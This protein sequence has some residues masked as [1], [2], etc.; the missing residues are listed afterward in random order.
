MNATNLTLAL[1]CGGFF[2]AGVHLLMARSLVRVAMGVAPGTPTLTYEDVRERRLHH[3][4]GARSAVR[5]ARTAGDDGAVAA[6][7][8][9]DA[10]AGT[11]I[12]P[13]A[14]PPA[15]PGSGKMRLAAGGERSEDV[16]RRRADE[17]QGIDPFAAPADLKVGATNGGGT[18]QATC[19]QLPAT[20]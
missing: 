4:G 11:Q 6:G 13:A 10:D 9:G 7:V 20:G 14:D 2:A 18:S 12:D 15:Q 5:T 3:L 1:L 19:Y 8:D 17:A 16:G